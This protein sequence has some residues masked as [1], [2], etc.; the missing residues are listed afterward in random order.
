M[1]LIGISL[2]SNDKH[3]IILLGIEFSHLNWVYWVDFLF[4]YFLD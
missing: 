3:L 2:I 4:V 1:D